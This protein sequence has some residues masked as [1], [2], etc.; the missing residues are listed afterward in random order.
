MAIGADTGPGAGAESGHPAQAKGVVL[1]HLREYVAQ[2]H[3]AAKWGDIQRRMQRDDAAVWNGLV[4]ASSWYPMAT[5]NRSLHAFAHAFD[6]PD[7]EVRKFGEFIAE[8]DLHTIFRILLRVAPPDALLGRT[9]S[10]WTRYFDS[11]T[12]TPE[13]RGPRSWQM[14]I[15][16]PVGEAEAPGE[17]TCRGVCGWVEQALVLTGTKT[18]RVKEVGCRFAG[19]PRCSFDVTW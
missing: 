15:D 1:L 14:I 6:A 19:V 10:L 18:A 11:G 4:L 8:R 12:L 5:W 17:L 7:A 9:G 3:G 2:R 13:P 16:A